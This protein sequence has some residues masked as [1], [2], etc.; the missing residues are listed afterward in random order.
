[1]RTG[2]L[3]AVGAVAATVV[4]LAGLSVVGGPAPP[5]D[6]QPP[7]GAGTVGPANEPC[8][9][10]GTQATPSTLSSVMWAARPGAII[11]L[12]AGNYSPFTV[13]AGADGAPVTV[14]PYNCEA[15]SVAGTVGFGSN[16]VLAGVRISHDESVLGG[17]GR[18]GHV[19]RTD[20]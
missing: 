8:T 12:R 2:V 6:A 14:K 13:E 7:Y 11:L 10:V 5:V 1:M 19:Q 17:P 15:V 3:L 18:T 20:P 4:T 16:T 9:T